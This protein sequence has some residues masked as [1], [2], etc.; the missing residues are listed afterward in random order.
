MNIIQNRTQLIGFSE[1]S[2]AVLTIFLGKMYQ[3]NAEKRLEPSASKGSS[4]FYVM[5]M[6][7]YH[8][9]IEFVV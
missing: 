3:L 1:Q 4:L 8:F 2:N 5:L 9:V 6:L 7:A